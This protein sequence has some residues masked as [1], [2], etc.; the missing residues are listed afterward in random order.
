M[1]FR[2]IKK[3]KHPIQKTRSKKYDFRSRGLLNLISTSKKTM[4]DKINTAKL[5]KEYNV[6]LSNI[7][8][9]FNCG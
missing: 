8:T 3:L 4:M 5:K 6:W 2:Y 9:I 7:S 1:K